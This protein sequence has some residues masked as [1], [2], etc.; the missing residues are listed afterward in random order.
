MNFFN[1]NFNNNENKLLSLAHGCRTDVAVLNKFNANEVS[2]LNF[3][4]YVFYR[5]SIDFNVSLKKTAVENR[6]CN[7]Y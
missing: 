3:K 1:I 6:C 5:K 4:K 2:I 7:I